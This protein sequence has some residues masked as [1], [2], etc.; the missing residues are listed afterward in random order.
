M[1]ADDEGEEDHASDR[2]NYGRA[3][4]GSDSR[5]SG[6]RPRLVDRRT[7]LIGHSLVCSSPKFGGL[8]PD[9]LFGVVERVSGP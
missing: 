1:A 2:R 5:L 4:L 6:R 8:G 9:L 7:S 3:L